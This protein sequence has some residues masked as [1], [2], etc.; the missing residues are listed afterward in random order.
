MLQ[1]LNDLAKITAVEFN[2]K[3]RTTSRIL[4]GLKGSALR[5]TVLH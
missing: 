4:K 1:L 5:R 3:L 2:L